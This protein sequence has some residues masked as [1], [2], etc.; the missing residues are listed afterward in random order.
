MSRFIA[1][2]FSATR[3]VVSSM[4]LPANAQDD[5]HAASC[6]ALIVGN[7]HGQGSDGIFLPLHSL[8]PGSW[9]AVEAA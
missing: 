9:R 8:E 5:A 1:S 6:G 7:G 4:S 2:C 3:A